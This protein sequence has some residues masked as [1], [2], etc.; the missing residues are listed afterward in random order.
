MSLTKNFYGTPNLEDK[1]A[2]LRCLLFQFSELVPVKISI[3]KKSD[4]FG[5]LR[6]VLTIEISI[7]FKQLSILFS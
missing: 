2:L 4:S 6:N 7:K 1:Q 3:F 5:I